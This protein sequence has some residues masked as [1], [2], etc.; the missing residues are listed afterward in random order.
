MTIRV[1]TGS[2]RRDCIRSFS[3]TMAISGRPKS[4]TFRAKGGAPRF[5]EISVP[6]RSVNE[7][8]ELRDGTLW[9]SE[10]WVD[11]RPLWDQ[12][13]RQAIR[14]PGVPV[15]LAD[16]AGSIW[17]AHDLG[18][19]T[20]PEVA[21]R[22]ARTYVIPDMREHAARLKCRLVLSTAP[23]AG[24]RVEISV[25]A[26]LHTLGQG[27]RWT[28]AFWSAFV[29]LFN[30][31]T[32]LRRICADGSD[33]DGRIV[34]SGDVWTLRLGTANPGASVVLSSVPVAIVKS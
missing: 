27:P 19:L 21:G 7:F 12:Q 17:L 34:R 8:A 10:A 25:P 24:T 13:G 15:M 1:L 6:N 28:H 29:S 18:A 9:I 2:R 23:G 3:I 4:S 16:K 31:E 14:I 32:S 11:I 20:S 33:R 22:E 5:D 26:A 30:L